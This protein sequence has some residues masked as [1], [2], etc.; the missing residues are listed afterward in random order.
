MFRLL[1]SSVV[2]FG[3]NG[4]QTPLLTLLLWGA[5]GS[6]LAILATAA[7]VNYRAVH[8]HLAR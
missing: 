3:G 1:R 6:L 2:Y 8:E 7:R 5:A 4:S